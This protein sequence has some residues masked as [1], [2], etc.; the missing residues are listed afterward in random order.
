MLCFGFNEIGLEGNLEDF[1]VVIK[2]LLVMVI[3]DF[4][5]YLFFVKRKKNI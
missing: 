2:C 3:V 5:D 4:R 1:Y